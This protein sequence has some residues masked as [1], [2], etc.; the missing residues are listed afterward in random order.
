MDEADK[1]QGSLNLEFIFWCWQAVLIPEVGEFQLRSCMRHTPIIIYKSV[2]G[3]VTESQ[4]TFITHMR[5]IH[6]QWIIGCIINIATDT[7]ITQ[8][9]VLTKTTMMSMVS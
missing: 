7:Y 5:V 8:K 1:L 4:K 6:L 3:D 9:M 2:T